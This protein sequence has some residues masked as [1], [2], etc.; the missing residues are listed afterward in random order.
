MAADGVARWQAKEGSLPGGLG[1][2]GLD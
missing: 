2:R 1:R